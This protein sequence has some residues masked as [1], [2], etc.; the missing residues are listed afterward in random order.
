MRLT[1]AS[2]AVIKATHCEDIEMPSGVAEGRPDDIALLNEAMSRLLFLPYRGEII[3]G[4]DLTDGKELLPPITIPP[5]EDE[6]MR[7]PDFRIAEGG[8]VVYLTEA[9]RC[10]LVRNH[11]LPGATPKTSGLGSSK[12]CLI[13]RSGWYLLT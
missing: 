9:P 1:E 5:D 7:I 8:G 11:C 4:F 3:A 13:A 12:A 2:S 6:G 10:A